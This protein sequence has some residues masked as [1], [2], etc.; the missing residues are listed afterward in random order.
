MS[1]E[2]DELANFL[3]IL[4]GI[5][6]HKDTNNLNRAIRGE[7]CRQINNYGILS[8][9]AIA[10]V[11]GCSVW[12]VE[13]ALSGV[14]RPNTRGRLNPEHLSML[15]YMLSNGK[16]RTEWL[17]RMLEEGTSLSTISDLTG[18]AES[19]LQRHRRKL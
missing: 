3:V 15:A 5:Y 17:G 16:V 11:V 19:T 1:T 9:R 8:P 4:N 14:S 13:E 18:I 6:L 12:Q 10:A 7:R 2:K